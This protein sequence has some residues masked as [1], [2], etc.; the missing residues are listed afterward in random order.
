MEIGTLP[1]LVEASV[2]VPSDIFA[3]YFPQL[4]VDSF[5]FLLNFLLKDN[6]FTEF[7]LLFVKP[8]HESAMKVKVK[9]K[10]LSRV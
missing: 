8:Q 7:L 5:F 4:W 1:G 10:S 3:W 2:I 9:V 6:C